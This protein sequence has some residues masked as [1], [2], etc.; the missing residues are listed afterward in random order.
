MTVGS[1][2]R[3]FGKPLVFASLLGIVMNPFAAWARKGAAPHADSRYQII[4]ITDSASVRLPWSRRGLGGGVF[5]NLKDLA[6]LVDEST[7]QGRVLL[8]YIRELTADGQEPFILDLALPSERI[9]GF[10]HYWTR[11]DSLLR[12]VDFTSLESESHTNEYLGPIASIPTMRYGVATYALA[13][14]GEVFHMTGPAYRKMLRS[15]YWSHA[16]V[17]L[18]RDESGRK[19]AVVAMRLPTNSM[20]S[21]DHHGIYAVIPKSF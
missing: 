7:E 21:L 12:V 8:A 18:S 17:Y 10:N 2:F 14:D 19:M 20:D 11:K 15:K 16:Q 1:I 13:Y 9:P 6:P 4:K 5:L 3:M